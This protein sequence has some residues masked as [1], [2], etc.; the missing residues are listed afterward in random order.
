VRRGADFSHR[1][2]RLLQPRIRKIKGTNV[3][4]Q[5][6]DAIKSLLSFGLTVVA[7]ADAQGKTVEI[8]MT[9]S[10][11]VPPTITISTGDAVTWINPAVLLHT[12]TFDPAEVADKSNIQLPAGVQP[13]GSG[14]LSEQGTFTH[15]FAEKGIYA[16]V[17][18]YHE[19]M[20]MKGT[21]VVS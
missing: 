11:F 2:H 21:V 3:T 18:K 9:D 4:L 19:S 17:C 5:R 8:S 6:R 13:F 10:A 15:L 14:D 16:Y 1:L 20:G 7:S 12:V